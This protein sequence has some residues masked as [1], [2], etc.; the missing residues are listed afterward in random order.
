MLPIQVNLA[1]SN[2]PVPLPSSGSNGAV[3]AKC[4]ITEPSFA[5]TL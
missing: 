5:A 4:A 3:W 1:A 2:R